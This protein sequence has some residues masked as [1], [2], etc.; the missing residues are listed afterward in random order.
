MNP[1]LSQRSVDESTVANVNSHMS[2]AGGLTSFEKNQISDIQCF[3]SDFITD[4]ELFSGG[5]GESD[6]KEAENLLN[7][8]R[9]I[10][11]VGGASTAIVLQPQEATRH[12]DQMLPVFLIR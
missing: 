9:A 10:H 4:L 5:T 7:K 2:G 8:S 1:L 12:A 6:A 11:P 3:A